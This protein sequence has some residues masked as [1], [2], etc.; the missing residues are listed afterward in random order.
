MDVEGEKCL[1]LI[2]LEF[3]KDKKEVKKNLIISA[4]TLKR[5]SHSIILS[6]H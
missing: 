5:I 4:M 6:Y 1:T 2:I 3:D